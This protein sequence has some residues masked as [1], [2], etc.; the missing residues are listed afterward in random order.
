[1]N[2]GMAL[3]RA[4][5][6]AGFEARMIL[7]NGEQLMV[8]IIFPLF[9][10]VLL[11]KT[12]VVSI[13]T[14]GARRIDVVA[15]GVVALAVMTTSFTSQA[16]ATAFDRRN[17]VL[18]LMATTPLGKSGLLIGKIAG[19]FAVEAVQIALIAIVA[20]FLGWRPDPAGILPALLMVVVG[21]IAFTALAMLAAGTLRAEAVL[22]VANLVLAAL[23]VGGGVLAPVSQLPGF[24]QHLALFLPSGAL[25]EAMRGALQT[26][27]LPPICVIILLAWSTALGWGVNKLFRWS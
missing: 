16:I 13:A 14:G 11:A 25:G 19:V 18:R 2:D 3:R 24:W 12:D 4:F 20:A 17:G 1:M 10:L 9:L 6:Q 5:S 21:T 15:P 22:A 27:S 7:R 8:T 23:V 26:G